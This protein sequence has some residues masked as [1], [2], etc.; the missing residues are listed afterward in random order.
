M[1]KIE[2]VNKSPYPQYHSKLIVSHVMYMTRHYFAVSLISRYQNNLK[3]AGW[4]VV[5][6]IKCY[7]R[8]ID[9]S[10][11]C[12]Q[13]RGIEL[14]G[15][16]NIDWGSDLDESKSTSGHAF[17]LSGR[18]MSWCAKKQS[19]TTMLAMDVDCVSC[20]IETKSIAIGYIYID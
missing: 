10:V 4:Q 5:K 1:T 11:F 16:S 2:I 3:L 6:R 12:Y 17:N 14:R 19:C 9:N 18:A 15:Y 20:T 8:G 13:G 7:L